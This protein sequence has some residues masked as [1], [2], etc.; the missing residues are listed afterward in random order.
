MLQELRDK[1]L[2]LS[3]DRQQGKRTDRLMAL[4]IYPET[5]EKIDLG[6]PEQTAKRIGSHCIKNY[7][8]LGTTLVS[9][10]TILDGFIRF[11]TL[12]TTINSDPIIAGLTDIASIAEIGVGILTASSSYIHFLRRDNLMYSIS[13]VLKNKTRV[14][15]MQNLDESPRTPASQKN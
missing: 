1:I 6:F 12:D 2:I 9:A 13:E 4:V 5:T 11:G 15:L 8:W 14:G 7:F 10:A 3:S